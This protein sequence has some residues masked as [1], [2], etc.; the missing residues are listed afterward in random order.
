MPV[1]QL[2]AL[3]LPRNVPVSSVIV[4]CPLCCDSTIVKE[5]F[6]HDFFGEQN[7]VQRALGQTIGL[8]V[9]QNVGQFQIVGVVKDSKQRRIDQLPARV[10]CF[11][12]LQADLPP[13]LMGH[14]TIEVRTASE[15]VAMTNAIRE[16]ERMFAWLASLFGLLTLL[17]ASVGLYGVIEYSTMRRTAE[18]GVRMALGAH[19]R[20]VMAMV[21]REAL[22]LTAIGVVI[23]LAL[24]P[25]VGRVVS[26]M[27]YGVSAADPLTILG[28]SVLMFVAAALAAFLPA[29]RAMRVDP[30][31]AL[32]YE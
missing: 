11:P 32:R 9:D 21:L 31:V 14:M 18:I 3:S 28:A 10:V 12:F 30:I 5:T 22:R 20:D 4:C 26:T 16:G 24:A 2:I 25:A 27:L 17:L 23:G 1:A 6:A 13:S 29:R 7:G 8:G 15:P 19:R